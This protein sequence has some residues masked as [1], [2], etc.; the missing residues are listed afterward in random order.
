MDFIH[1]IIVEA[2]ILRGVGGDARISNK[3]DLGI[4]QVN[5][6]YLHRDY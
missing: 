2:Q 5:L 1:R 4:S 6:R 3:H